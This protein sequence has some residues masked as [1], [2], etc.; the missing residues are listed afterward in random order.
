VQHLR[1]AGAAKC[2]V[3]HRQRRHLRG[4]VRPLP[5]DAAADE[6]DRLRRRRVGPVGCDKGINGW[7]EALNVEGRRCVGRSGSVAGRAKARD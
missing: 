4:Q 5:E 2:P 1:G 6:Q 3:E 7:L